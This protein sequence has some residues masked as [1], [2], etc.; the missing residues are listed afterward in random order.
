MIRHF[1]SFANVKRG[2][3]IDPKK[4]KHADITAMKIQNISGWIDPVTH[5]NLDFPKHLI[6]EVYI[7]KNLKLGSKV[8]IRD[9][10]LMAAFVSPQAYMH[11]G[12]VDEAE[13]AE[14]LR[15]AIS[16]EIKNKEK[17]VE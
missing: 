3:V 11:L 9:E 16:K 14:Q 1:T 8:M 15:E 2:E 12:F 7:A 17:V 10:R 5:L 13:R 6:R 4:V